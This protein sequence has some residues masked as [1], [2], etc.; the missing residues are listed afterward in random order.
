M[1][2]DA[3]CGSC[4]TQWIYH[5]AAA[6]LPEPEHLRLLESILGAMVASCGTLRCMGRISNRGTDAAFAL[7]PAARGAYAEAKRASNQAAAELL[8]A[9]WEYIQAG[10][11][12]GERF[13]RACSVAALA[14]IAP[15]GVPTGPFAFDELRG[16]L[17]QGKPQPVLAGDVA[18]NIGSRRV[19]YALD[20]AGEVGFDSLAIRVLKKAGAHVTLVVKEPAFF[21][22]ATLEDARFFS[23]DQVV[24]Q[25]VAVDGF[26]V[27]E[28]ASAPAA[29]A[30]ARCD[31]V[32]AKGTGS[33]EALYGELGATPGLFLLKV[34][35][36]PISNL[37]GIAE[38][39]FAVAATP[40]AAAKGYQ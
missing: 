2:P 36:R 22:D 39:N 23:L 29:A 34:K 14:N 19:V 16:L 40:G 18:S 27:P 9:A 7:A 30:L 1:R 21:E 13:T 15:L 25:V 32:I 20:N 17:D 24:D 3:E 12:A 11:T 35:C 38:S 6:A 26:L 31:L 8:P 37:L 10:G 33:F 4:I 28:D 5:R